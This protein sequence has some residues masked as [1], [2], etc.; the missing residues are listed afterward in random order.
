MRTRFRKPKLDGFNNLSKSLSFTLYDVCYARD[1]QD[2]Q[3]YIAYIDEAYNAN[4]LTDIL[5]EVTRMI[6]AHLLNVARQDYDPQGASVTMLISEDPVDAEPENPEQPG[7][8]P[9][10]VV[11]HLNKSHI[12]VHTY[13]EAHPYN[14]IATFRAD[15]E[16]STCGK[17]SPLR[18][19]NFL[20]HQFD[21]DVLTLDYRVRG[22]TR[23]V[24]GVKHYL[25]HSVSSIQNFISR[26]IL[27]D[28]QAID[29]NNYQE[30]LFH[31]KMFRKEIDIEHYLFAGR[32]RTQNPDKAEQNR[33]RKAVSR[34]IQEIYYGR[35]L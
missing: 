33:I 2:R 25:D 16:V 4:R 22:F 26:E 11:G 8:V 19:L 21:A 6:G 24:E 9:V 32:D 30:N 5:S 34:E 29:V 10:A 28:Y 35:N 23:D 13:P 27:D 18:A 14:G 12:T 3:N 15:I 20:I 1:V 7:P 17:I 31:T